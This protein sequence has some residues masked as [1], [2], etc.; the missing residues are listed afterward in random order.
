VGVDPGDV[1][2]CNHIEVPRFRAAG[3]FKTVP[4]MEGQVVLEFEPMKRAVEHGV[5]CEYGGR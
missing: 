4:G 1:P 2:S 3:V 5:H